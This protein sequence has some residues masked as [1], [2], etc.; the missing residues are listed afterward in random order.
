MQQLGFCDAYATHDLDFSYIQARSTLKMLVG[1]EAQ[2]RKAG[3]HNEAKSPLTDSSSP[4]PELAGIFPPESAYFSVCLDSI[5][6]S[7]PSTFSKALRPFFHFRLLTGIFNRAPRRIRSTKFGK[8]I[9]APLAISGRMLRPVIPG[10][11][12]TSK[13]KNRPELPV[14]SQIGRASC[15]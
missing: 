5:V 8:S 9:P 7:H 1:R 4:D 13:I 14:S 3:Q 6:A 10:K 15:R 2:H 11:V 12:F